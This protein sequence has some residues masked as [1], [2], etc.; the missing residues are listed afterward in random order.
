MNEKIPEMPEKISDIN[1]C[2]LDHALQ[3][4]FAGKHSCGIRIQLGAIIGP[5]E[6]RR[7]LEFAERLWRLA[8]KDPYQY[9]Q[10]CE[11]GLSLH[12]F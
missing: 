6:E 2:E 5:G 4:P 7:K 3:C 12:F 11:K 8:Y 10:I 9:R 1:W